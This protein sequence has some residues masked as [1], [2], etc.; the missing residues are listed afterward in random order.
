MREGQLARLR[1]YHIGVASIVAAVRRCA[2][3][4]LGPDERPCLQHHH[5]AGRALLIVATVLVAVLVCLYTQ[6][7]NTRAG[8]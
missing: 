8:S 5:R 3:A 7:Y 2:Q 6:L 1:S 4:C